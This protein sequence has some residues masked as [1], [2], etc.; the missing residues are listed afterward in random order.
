MAVTATARADDPATVGARIVTSL[1]GGTSTDSAVVS[2]QK[3]V[4]SDATGLLTKLTSNG[5]FSDIDYSGAPAADW[6][7]GTHF[8]R[9]L[10][11]AQA[12][13]VQGGSLYHSPT[14]LT[15]IQSA[16]TYGLVTST[17]RSGTARRPPGAR[18]A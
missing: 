18:A 15:S 11:L 17:V 6:G 2:L 3:S 13:Q 10:T 5:S 4:V 14:L 12:Y 8:S 7:V 16:L 1:T 9:V